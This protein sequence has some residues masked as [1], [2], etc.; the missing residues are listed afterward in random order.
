MPSK[1]DT[2][3]DELF[4]NQELNVSLSAASKTSPDEYAK[5]VQLSREMGVPSNVVQLDPKAFENKAQI[6]RAKKAVAYDSYAAKW[7][8]DPNNAKIAHDDVENLGA[9]DA[10]LNGLKMAGRY[11]T[12]SDDRGSLLRDMKAGYYQASAGAAGA[13]RAATDIAA[14]PF[15]ILEQFPVIGGNPL[16]RLE[17]GF[18]MA[19]RDASIAADQS[20]SQ[21]TSTMGGGFSSGVQSL[22]Q[23]LLGLPMAFLPGGQGAYLGVMS[24]QSGGLSYQKAADAGVDRRT[25]LMYGASDAV[26]EYA[27]EKLP[28]QKLLGGLSESAPLVKTLLKTAA[29]EIPGEQIATVLQDMNEWAVLNPE[30]P[31]SEYLA[32]RPSAAAQTLIAT[33]VGTGGMVTVAHGLQKLTGGQQKET[34]VTPLIEQV[35]KLAQASKVLQRDPQ[36]VEQFVAQATQDGVTDLYIDADMLNQ[37]GIADQVAEVSPA[38]REQ[39]Q[40]AIATGGTIRI[41]MSEYVAYIA[42]KSELATPLLDHLKDDP[43]GFSRA[44]AETFKK[45]QGPALEKEITAVL[46]KAQG[47][48]AF[49]ESRNAVKQ[50]VLDQLNTVGRNTPEVNEA[51]AS[52]IAART[53][54]RAGQ[55]GITPEAMMQK[56]M[57]GIQAEGMSAD[58]LNQSGDDRRKA[59]RELHKERGVTFTDATIDRGG[60]HSPAGPESGSPAYDVALN[61][62]YPEDFYGPSGLRYYGT[63]ADA[64]DAEMYSQLHRMAGRP[65]AMITVY[66][67]VG[68]DGSKNIQAG[69]WVTPVR[70]YAKEHAESSIG[71]KYKIIKKLVRAR[72]IWTAG[73]SMLEWGYHPQPF[74]PEVRNTKPDTLN[75]SAS[76]NLQTLYQPTRA[77]YSPSKNII[78]LLKNADLSSFLHESAHYFFEN[79]IAL[80]K[81]LI[82]KPEHTAGEKQILDDV[83]A[84]LTWH[85]LE[86][87]VNEQLDQWNQMDFEQKRAHH[88]RT[89]ESFEKYLFE[90]KAPNIELATYFQKFREFMLN[91]YKSL[92]SFLAKH[93][94]AG[95]LNDEVRGVFDRMLATD[96]QIVLAEQARSMLPLFKTADEALQFGV[97][98]EQY[99][100]L[101]KDATQAAVTALQAAGMRDMQW[102][103]AAKGREVTKLKKQSEALRREIRQQVRTEI[104]QRP[105]YQAWSFLTNRM[106]AEDKLPKP[107]KP[108]TG[109]AEADKIEAENVEPGLGLNLEALGAGRL[110]AALIQNMDLPPEVVKRLED[111]KMTSKTGGLHPDIVAGMPFIGMSSGDELARALYDADPPNVAIEKATDARMLAENGEL[112]TPEAI[113]KAANKALYNLARGKMLVADANALAQAT[114]VKKDAG[115]DKRGRKR[116]VNILPKVAQEAAASLIARL[117]IRNLKPAQYEAAEMK[118][119]KL[120]E[121]AKNKGDIQT[122]AAQARTRLLNH[123]AAKAAYDAVDEVDAGRKYLKKV[124]EPGKIPAEHFDQ[125]QS[126]LAKF[127]LRQVT[128]KS[129]DNTAMFQTWARA[130][131]EAGNIPPNIELLLTA[132]QR[133][134]YAREVNRINEDGSPVY[135]DEEAQAVLLASMLDQ[136]PVRNYRQLTIEEFRSLVEA[137]KQIEHMGKRTRKVLTDRKK[138]EFAAV[139]KNISENIIAVATKKD[140]V[141]SDVKTPTP[142]TLASKHLS[143]RGFWGSHIKAATNVQI[144][145]GGYGGPM[146]ETLIL[147]ANEAGNGEVTDSA[148]A[149]KA[150]Q[151]LLKPVK[152]LGNITDRPKHFPS[153]GE[154]LNRQ[155]RIVMAMNLGNESN[156]Q[157]LLGGKNWTRA[158]IQPV[159]DTLTE[160]DWKFVQGMWDMYE[161]YRPRI[162]ALEREI[163][164]V[165]PEWIEARPLTVTTQDGKTLKLRGGYAPVI[166]DPRASGKAASFAAEK[167]A[168]AMMQAARV[169]STVNKSFTKQRVNEVKGRPLFLSLDAMIG[170]IQDTIHYLHWQPWIIDANR[171]VKALDEPIRT[172]YGAETVSQLR[173]W[174]GDNAAGTRPARDGAERVITSLARNVSFAGLAFN[175]FSA[176][177]QVTG[178]SQSV[179]VVGTKWMGKGVAKTLQ[180]PRKAYTAATEKSA[181]MRKRGIT[182]MRDLAE[183]HTVVRDQGPIRTAL[184]ESGYAM[185]LAMQ[186]AVDVPTWWAGYEKA[187]DAGHDEADAISRADQAVIDSQGSGMAKDLAMVERS[188]GALRL[189]TGFMSFMNTTLNANYRVLKSDD[190]AGKKAADLVLINVIPVALTM[191]LK[192]ILFPSGDDD[193][194]EPTQ[195]AKEY[196]A[197]QISFMFGQ[198]IGFREVSQIGAAAM[199]LPT[200]GYQ[201]AVGMRMFADSL[202]LAQQ[203]GQGDP[204]LPLLKTAVSTA[205]DFLRLPGTQ[206]NRTITGT[207]ALLSDETDNPAAIVFGYRK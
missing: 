190:S 122:A 84:L 154:S 147:S 86:G 57:L 1:Y 103:D 108:D 92:K 138:R 110:D 180:N 67:S 59:L 60:A 2:A 70:A 54:V 205:S 145:D 12:G 37:S 201:G 91:V 107:K 102:I 171:L 150:V 191:L 112:A 123:Y 85:G 156:E 137:V 53:A 48:D 38:V 133:A 43:L 18:G 40:D 188:S 101:A 198:M 100:A 139:V 28:L 106:T 46:E 127:D 184:D 31:F 169:A 142:G 125:I 81:E 160:A 99:Q 148:D 170:G 124:Q 207:E 193:E 168:K 120:V 118:A 155:E 203:V 96:E 76:E 105:V 186:S 23:N 90:G 109:I 174:V 144:M 182:R 55:L 97:D 161:T 49:N 24:A 13:F 68:E 61:E 52:L 177:Q 131:L 113:D 74:L 166:F 16:R 89:A 104:M 187:L 44:E 141:S 30:K 202:K 41:P 151:E 33:V 195:L 116:T 157:R 136:S 128:N 80:A 58:A 164:G 77:G 10:T 132:Q 63:G 64:M 115:T 194:R 162:A 72:D 20:R 117:Q 42:P 78:T 192:S 56:Q 200:Y 93:P 75:Q 39:L 181:F 35:N 163:N 22:T 47:D 19:G 129:L 25:A 32:E 199:G 134:Q 176:V 4:G 14:T 71:G 158:Q 130:Q 83:H 5:S 11:V 50:S 114:E 17:E 87:D 7:L 15:D 69:D 95:K 65:N 189:L 204:D 88:E 26:I 135:A 111:F 121:K 3:A 66:R 27:T 73:D 196:A 152:E 29:A 98:F 126:L 94:E 8:S 175:L 153:I 21:F 9:L 149:Y 119:G 197:E 146:W 82:A 6:D 173:A 159:L 183:T 34:E 51:Y 206:I 36:T 167:D 178:Y 79:D 45:E 172:H 143:W 185:M 140:R 165:E 179:A 62:T